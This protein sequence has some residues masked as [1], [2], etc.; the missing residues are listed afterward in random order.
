[1]GLREGE[2]KWVR[3]GIDDGHRNWSNLG[4]NGNMGIVDYGRRNSRVGTRLD[5]HRI[6]VGIAM[7]RMI[8]VVVVLDFG[9]VVRLVLCKRN[10]PFLFGL[11]GVEF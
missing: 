3:G 7:N 11:C 2:S 9:I 5:Y 4:R 6:V 8:V 1:M 10:N